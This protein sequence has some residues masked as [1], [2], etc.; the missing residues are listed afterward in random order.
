MH[1]KDMAEKMHQVWYKNTI[2]ETS[3]ILLLGHV[4]P[5]NR[6]CHITINTNPCI[7]GLWGAVTLCL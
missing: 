5:W 3:V 7:L 6:I 4:N 2:E 1:K